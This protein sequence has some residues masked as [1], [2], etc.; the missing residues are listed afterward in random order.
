VDGVTCHIF[1]SIIF[2]LSS[3]TFTCLIKLLAI[4]GIIHH[5]SLVIK[6]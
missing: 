1:T 4:V 5:I 3:I 2:P 6:E